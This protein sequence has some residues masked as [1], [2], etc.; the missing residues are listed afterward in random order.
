MNV[1]IAN[2][3]RTAV[4]SATTAI[5]IFVLY[6]SKDHITDIA[7]W[8]GLHGYQ[9]YTLFVL[10][11]IVAL[12][13]KVLNTK[14]FAKSTRTMGFKLMLAAGAMSL[15]CNVGSGFLHGSIGAASYGAFIVALFVALEQVVI[16]IKPAASVT[17]A[18]TRAA[19]AAP[20]GPQLT[21]RQ[22]AARKGAATRARN[23]AKSV[24][25]GR[26][27]IAELNVDMARTA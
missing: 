13:G 4:T 9:A 25:P 1:A 16:R 27:P 11:D 10:I 15:A 23:A 2:R 26:V 6:V 22:V 19:K 24:S 3:V 21:A 14:Y 5:L 17:A 12:I 18:K 8:L 20:A 7:F